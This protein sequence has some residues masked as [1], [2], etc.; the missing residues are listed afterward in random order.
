[1]STPYL[2]R[3]RSEPGETARKTI[4]YEYAFR[5]SLSGIPGTTLS[6]T[7]TVSIE[8]TFVAVSIGYGVTPEATTL[9]FGASPR[10]PQ[11]IT[12][13]PVGAGSLV[14]TTFADVIDSIATALGEKEGAIGPRTAAVLTNGFRLNPRLAQRILLNDGRARLDAQVLSRM[15]E[16]V[17]TFTAGQVQFLYALRDDGTGREFQSQPIL[18]T[19]GL[20][21]A[22]GERPF[23]YFATPISFAPRSTIRMDV[24]EISDFKG[25][26]HVALHGYKVLGEAGTPTDR[27]TAMRR[28]TARIR[29]R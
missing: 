27:V 8:S 13:V 10:S 15:F 1:M 2:Q 3:G 7:V 17:G 11:P 4:P 16:S 9:T 26:L 21:T 18:N 25:D 6:N 22:A 20:G 29:R 23:R 24:T 19:A 12:N 28:R 5:Y 14:T